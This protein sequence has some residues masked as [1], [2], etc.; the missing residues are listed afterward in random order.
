M[1]K[2]VA[3]LS[4][5]LVMVTAGMGLSLTTSGASAD[6]QAVGVQL[7]RWEYNVPGVDTA[8][9]AYRESVKVKNTSGVPVNMTGWTVEDLTGHTFHFPSGYILNA[10]QEVNVRTGVKPSTLGGWWANPAAN[11]Y[12]NRSQHMYANG[13]AGESVVLQNSGSTVDRVNK[14]PFTIRP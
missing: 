4:A 9:N 10:G 5:A 7:V 2:R 6:E 14:N 11:L 8:A 12:W 13:T 1:S 3:A